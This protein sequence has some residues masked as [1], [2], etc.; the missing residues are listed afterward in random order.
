[1]ELRRKLAR[2]GCDPL[3]I[4]GA[5]RRL[6][7]L[8][9][10]NDSEYASALVARRSHS[11]GRAL[12]ARELAAKG[13]DRPLA[14]AALLAIDEETERIGALRLAE[15]WRSLPSD[16]LAARLQRRGFSLETIAV[17]LSELKSKVTHADHGVAREES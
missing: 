14:A 8:G 6:R 9:Y 7:E 15:R 12:I 3:A 5:L 1:M 16:R 10:C 11:R 4:E 17:V 13:I 2:R